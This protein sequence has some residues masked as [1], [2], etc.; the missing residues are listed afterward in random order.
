M[1]FNVRPLTEEILS[2]AVWSPQHHIQR[3][4]QQTADI[5]NLNYEIKV[6][7][8][9]FFIEVKRKNRTIFST[10]R[11]ALIAGEN[12]FEWS[13]HLGSGVQLIAGFDE[14]FQMD[15]GRRILINNQHQSVIPFV[16]GFGKIFIALNV[17]VFKVS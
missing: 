8:P 15:E 12:Y 1:K 10:S 13:F 16:V 7:A 17:K 2:I 6:F 14:L 4:Q 9:E 3:Q 11:G 5:R